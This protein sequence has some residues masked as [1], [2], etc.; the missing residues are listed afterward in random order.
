MNRN[1]LLAAILAAA[2]ASGGAAVAQ[3]GDAY[4]LEGETIRFLLPSAAGGNTDNQTRLLAEHMAQYLPGEPSIIVQN[5]TGGGGLR[6]ME[7]IAQLDPA[8]DLVMFG[9][10]SS[11]PFRSAMGAVDPDQFDPRTTHWVGGF[12]GLTQFCIVSAGIET[13]DDM[14][15]TDMLFAATN[16]AG[17]AAAIYSLLEESLGLSIETVA[18]YDSFGLQVLAVSRGEVDG[19]CNNYSAYE[20]LIRPEVEAGNVRFAFYLDVAPREDIVDAPFFGDLP[21]PAEGVEVV[22]SALSAILFSGL[23]AVP[24]GSDPRFVAAMREAFDLTV[25]DPEFREAAIGYGIDLRYQSAADVDAR[26]EALYAMPTSTIEQI[27]RYF[28]E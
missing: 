28:G 9:P 22:Q 10:T 23:Y 26:V 4:T 16:A 27:G 18:G 6:M 20:S 8:E 1:R 15:D 3:D 14:M 17:T 2:L 11:M 13:F 19:M 7:F 25:A 24:E 12:R 5:L 21:F